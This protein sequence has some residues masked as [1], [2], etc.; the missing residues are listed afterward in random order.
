MLELIKRLC[1]LDGVS[2]W[3]DEV[4]DFLRAEAAP[5]ADDIR[6]DALGSLM[7][8]Q[9]G[10]TPGGR[11]LML[12]AHMDEVGLIVKGI[13]DE[14]HLKF[15]CVG[16]IDRRVLP[17]RR[18]SVGPGKRPGVIGLKAYHLVDREEEKK[19][20]KVEDMY[21]D[22]GA[23]S[24][25]EAEEKAALGDACVFYGPPADMGD[26]FLRAKAID[27]RFG[28]A[29]LLRRLKGKRPASD[30][31]TV[32]TAQ[33]EAGT[34]GAFGPAFAVA[35]RAA[36]IVEATTAA[37]LPGLPGHKQVCRPGGGVVIPTADRGAFYCP[38]L[39]RIAVSQ[40]E[41]L[42]I[43]WQDKEFVSGGTDAAALQTAR[44]GVETLG[45]AVAARY[46]HSPAT[47][48]CAA[49]FERAYR[50]FDAVADVLEEE[51]SHA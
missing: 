35:P 24:R 18:V 4:R 33:E 32:F 51:G 38:R 29:C 2:G 5:H 14:G 50:V 9:R 28:C 36:V 39:R 42:G 43:P 44:D 11:P 17:G 41:R 8:F 26:G 23:A 40:A 16:G 48:A 3:E 49:D 15:G 45:L 21:I 12:C 22:I 47:L 25:A 37:D 6:V 34:R 27:D 46:L 30:T 31:W 19:V 1:R 20:P 7:V 10:R 13:A